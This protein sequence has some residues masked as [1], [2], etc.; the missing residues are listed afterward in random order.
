MRIVIDLQGAQTESR[1]RGIGRYSI[2]IAR[3]I[4]RNNSRHEI[5]IALSSYSFQEQLG[6]RA[7][8]GYR[9][10]HMLQRVV[11]AD[12][13]GGVQK[14]V[15]R[16]TTAAGARNGA[17]AVAHQHKAGHTGDGKAVEGQRVDLDRHLPRA[18]QVL[19]LSDGVA[20]RTLGQA[21]DNN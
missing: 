16:R 20:Q 2:A 13:A 6:S 18:D 19:N 14:T 8:S 12:V 3:G 1:F 15:G 9:S 5:F 17:R 11:Q 21:P 7:E 4:I 10:L